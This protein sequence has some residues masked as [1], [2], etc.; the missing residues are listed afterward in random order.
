MS[1]TPFC[2]YSKNKMIKNI[3]INCM[4]YN[5][6]EKIF[7]V[8]NRESNLI[9]RYNFKFENQGDI[10]TSELP[11][12]ICDNKNYVIYITDD[13][14]LMYTRK[15]NSEKPKIMYRF[16]DYLKSSKYNN[17]LASTG[18]GFLYIICYNKLFMFDLQSMKIVKNETLNMGDSKP[19][20][21]E[22][23]N[24][25]L[26]IFYEYKQLYFEG[27][28][29]RIKKKYN[30]KC[31]NTI[32]TANNLDAETEYTDEIP[33]AVRTIGDMLYVAYSNRKIHIIRGTRLIDYDTGIIEEEY[34]LEKEV[35]E[36]GLIGK[37]CQITTITDD[38]IYLYIGDENGDLSIY[39]IDN[40]EE[41]Y[42]L[43]NATWGSISYVYKS[44]YYLYIASKS[45]GATM[46]LKNLQPFIVEYSDSVEVYN[47][48]GYLYINYKAILDHGDRNEKI[49]YRFQL[50]GYNYQEIISDWTNFETPAEDI[51]KDIKIIQSY[52][53]KYNLKLM[54]EIEDIHGMKYAKSYRLNTLELEEPELFLDYI[55]IGYHTVPITD[56]DM[57]YRMGQWNPETRNIDVFHEG[58]ISVLSTNGLDWI[59][60]VDDEGHLVTEGYTGVI[61]DY[62]KIPIPEDAPETFLFDLYFHKENEYY[63]KFAP[64]N[65][66][67]Y[68]YDVKETYE[69][70]MQS[71]EE[72]NISTTENFHIMD[73][74]KNTV[75][76][77]EV[78]KM[79]FRS[80][81]GKVWEMSIDEYIINDPTLEEQYASSEINGNI[82]M[83]ELTDVEANADQYNGIE[84]AN[85]RRLIFRNDSSKSK[86]G[87]KAPDGSIWNF[88][89]IRSG[90]GSTIRDYEGDEMCFI[91]RTNYNRE[92]L[93]DVLRALSNP[94]TFNVSTA[95]HEHSVFYGN[96]DKE[97]NYVTNL[98]NQLEYTMN[99]QGLSEEIYKAHNQYF[100][101]YING[102]KMYRQDINELFS[103]GSSTV[104]FRHEL[105]MPS[106]EAQPV[107]KSITGQTTW[108]LFCDKNG[109]LKASETRLNPTVKD[110]GLVLRYLEVIQEENK[111]TEIAHDYRLDIDDTGK[112][113]TVKIEFKPTWEGYVV[114]EGRPSYYYSLKVT[115]EG[116]YY[117]ENTGEI[118]RDDIVPVVPVLLSPD[119]TKA[120]QIMVGFGRNDDNGNPT[121]GR[122]WGFLMEN[123]PK[124][125]VEDEIYIKDDFN[126]IWRVD[127]NEGGRLTTELTHHLVDGVCEKF[128]GIDDGNNYIFT[129]DGGDAPILWTDQFI[130]F[131]DPSWLYDIHIFTEFRT[132]NV[133]KL[134]ENGNIIYDKDGL[135]IVLRTDTVP[136]RARLS[137][138]P[139]N[140]GTDENPEY[141]VYQ[142]E[143]PI[144]IELNHRNNTAAEYDISKRLI[145][146]ETDE[147]ELYNGTFAMYFNKAG[148]YIRWDDLSLYIRFNHTEYYTRIDRAN[149]ALRMVNQNKVLIQFKNYIFNTIGSEILLTTKNVNR[150]ITLNLQEKLDN[151]K[152]YYYVP[153]VQYDELGNLQTF[154]T[155][156][157]SQFEV[158]VDGYTLTPK[159]DYCLVN[160]YLHSH[161]PSMLVFNE[162][163][164][165]SSKVEI[166][167]SESDVYKTFVFDNPSNSEWVIIKD[168]T[169]MF[170]SKTFTVMC[171]GRK[172]DPSQY[173]IVDR[174]RLRL[175]VPNRKKI[176]VRFN[177]KK[178][179]NINKILQLLHNDDQFIDQSEKYMKTPSIFNGEKYKGSEEDP[180]EGRVYFIEAW[181][182]KKFNNY[183]DAIFDCNVENPDILDTPIDE[184]LCYNLDYINNDIVIDA[185]ET[186]DKWNFTEFIE[187]GLEPLPP[188]EEE[189]EEPVIVS[190]PELTDIHEFSETDPDTGE[191]IGGTVIIEFTV[192][193]NH[194]NFFSY[195]RSIDGDAYE[196]I[197]PYESRDLSIDVKEDGTYR[198]ANRT[199]YDTIKLLR[200]THTVSYR[201]CD[202]DLCTETET[203]TIR[204]GNASSSNPIFS[205]QPKLLSEVYYNDCQ[206]GMRV[207]N[208][209]DAIVEGENT[210]SMFVCVDP[211]TDILEWTPVNY[212]IDSSLVYLINMNL[213]YGKH[214]IHFKIIDSLGYEKTSVPLKFTLIKIE[215]PTITSPL[216]NTNIDYVAQTANFELIAVS[217]N[218]NHPYLEVRVY[219]DD[220]IINDA[221][222]E[223]EG[224]KY[225]IN[226][227]EQYPGDHN[228]YVEL[229][230]GL[231]TRVSNTVNFSLN[232]R[233]VEPVF[234]KQLEVVSID[235]H[236]NLELIFKAEDPNDSELTYTLEY[237]AVHSDA[238][239]D[240]FRKNIKYVVQPDYDDDK[241]AIIKLKLGSEVINI[242]NIIVTVTNSNRLSVRSNPIESLVIPSNTPAIIHGVDTQVYY[243]RVILQVIY[244]NLDEDIIESYL[245]IDGSPYVIYDNAIEY[246]RIV[247]DFNI[248]EPGEHTIKIRLFDGSTYANSEFIYVTTRN[249]E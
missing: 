74:V 91:S 131:S 226:L 67:Y 99:P 17:L 31:Y 130:S 125:I 145:E 21:I 143:E 219:L 178:Y 117:T 115:K 45:L 232:S 8:A 88:E 227:I 222:V 92:Q 218:P 59:L 249:R 151:S 208:P 6:T 54:I 164:K 148:E 47:K 214:T 201:V 108:K 35:F 128:V 57:H 142:P 216:V 212:V 82:I 50:I 158:V 11:K 200:G 39:K 229:Y 206:I 46:Y 83:K 106:N 197:Y 244:S 126:Y 241:N 162:C 68:I 25:R 55:S 12:F 180:S 9:T 120:Y 171:D 85:E 60:K 71:M 13:N 75:E 190:Q 90:N 77:V 40:K 56:I 102:L 104:R 154:Y 248:D 225:Y 221:I 118:Y 94:I 194:Q 133:L 44:T 204:M 24:N 177:Y 96:Y 51:D 246:E 22:T 224:D 18:N 234:T 1:Y 26:F 140:K 70:L 139:M 87:L 119:K 192:D 215:P 113:S 53:E 213:T 172:L 199:I 72:G 97:G 65:G 109:N 69:V 239:D 176:I 245:S 240:P 144:E 181:S 207:F 4:Y 64:E 79:L 233:Y 80:P 66:E 153:L 184:E 230:D 247:L 121:N 138:L 236:G 185:N 157:I 89:V 52:V 135:P 19:I 7:Y 49:R 159:V 32:S 27:T 160:Y 150:T 111:R 127:V 152:P 198:L 124:D 173:L 20:M 112:I 73:I 30:I 134:D 61:Y 38:G 78:P 203:L 161:M 14:K 165:P 169:H 146:T 237:I 223:R 166:A 231:Y 101:V 28:K 95:F 116:E 141:E 103:K 167:F 189:N 174:K 43:N 84:I 183:E 202:G 58:D 186:Y 100:N 93:S 156:D 228:I 122:L 33:V 163:L 29:R 23:S 175:L 191:I 170:V 41:N 243:N 182:D 220:E 242:S 155:D 129:P 62:I 81:N 132:I 63:E 205:M 86:I 16:D 36:P 188:L 105:K 217:N 98:H 3:N 168:N 235:K 114:S 48:N 123:V 210:I 136:V 137:T 10:I 5:E 193:D 211:E 37:N 76:R 34:F 196:F 42:F 2:M 147:E 209:N 179:K 238:A 15:D 187:P 195:E 149:W 107:I 110:N